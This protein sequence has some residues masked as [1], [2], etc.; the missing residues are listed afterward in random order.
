MRHT[1]QGIEAKLEAEYSVA[2]SCVCRVGDLELLPFRQV[3]VR[4]PGQPLLS[5]HLGSHPPAMYLWENK[6]V[7]RKTHSRLFSVHK[8]L[9][10]RATYMQHPMNFRISN[11]I[12]Y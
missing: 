7:L 9:M 5:S 12:L 2:Y 6:N 4:D 3:R 8:K 10:S 11:D 1:G